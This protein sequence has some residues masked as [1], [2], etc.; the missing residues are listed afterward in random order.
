MAKPTL[1]D[2]KP[3]IRTLPLRPKKTKKKKVKSGPT[4]G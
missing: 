1:R 4:Y 3:K 2:A